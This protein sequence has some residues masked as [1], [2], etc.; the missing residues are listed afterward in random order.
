M[1]LSLYADNS[2]INETKQV[3]ILIAKFCAQ[4]SVVQLRMVAYMCGCLW[5]AWLSSYIRR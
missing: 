3:D 4:S 1:K 5:S 2:V